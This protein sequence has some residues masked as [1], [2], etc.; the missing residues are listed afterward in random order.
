MTA[1]QLLRRIEPA[2]SGGWAVKS[3]LFFDRRLT[4]Q[5]HTPEI[6]SRIGPVPADLARRTGGLNGYIAAVL[7]HGQPG[8]AP[9]VDPLAYLQQVEQGSVSE[10]LLSAYLRCGA[11]PVAVVT[12]CV[13]PVAVVWFR[14]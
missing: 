1:R 8:F 14:S 7:M 13:P 9:A 5:I 2:P 3:G 4:A 11:R 10:P 12:D 6:A